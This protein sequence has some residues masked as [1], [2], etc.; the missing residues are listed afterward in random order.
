MIHYA[1]LVCCYSTTQFHLT[2][3]GGWWDKN[4]T[5]V[6]PKVGFMLTD[7]IT[8]VAVTY[9]G[10]DNNIKVPCEDNWTCIAQGLCKN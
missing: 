9:F 8:I 3:V 6:T 10:N 5:M 7:K 4:E 2:E 1:A